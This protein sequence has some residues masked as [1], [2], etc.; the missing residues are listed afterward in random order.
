MESTCVINGKENSQISILAKMVILEPLPLP[1]SNRMAMDCLTWR[2]IPGSGAAIITINAGM[3][4]V[5]G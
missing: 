4:R 3:W 5:H 2:E 1:A